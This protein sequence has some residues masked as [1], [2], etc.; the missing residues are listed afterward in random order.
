MIDNFDASLDTALVYE[1]GYSDH[2]KDPGGKTMR[3]VTQRVYDAWRGRRKLPKR[4]V[5]AITDDELK[6]IYREQYWNVVQGDKLPSGVDFVVF[7]GA[8][9]SGPK[10]SVKWLQR[11]LGFNGSQVDGIV[12]NVTLSAIE[13]HEDHDALIAGIIDRRRVF[14]K[15]LKTWKTFGKG[16]TRRI[17]H[18]LE[19]GQAWAMGTVGPDPVY[20]PG[21]ERKAPV[22]DARDTLPKAPGDL[23]IGVGGAGGVG[24]LSID[25]VLN[26]A[27]DQLEPFQAFAWVKTLIVGLVIAGGIVAV[28][29]L[30]YRHWAAK[31]AA[32]RADALDL[33]TA[34]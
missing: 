1:G 11:A 30:V 25:Q 21:G 16:W 28:A 34:E 9:N 17:N 12:G 3:G 29:S 15:A 18:V 24:G 27:K 26:Q 7:D 8:V 19:T 22:T 33:E 20:V 14:L 10:Q 2:P 32:E 4:S 5:K 6:A 23:G 13:K 31:K